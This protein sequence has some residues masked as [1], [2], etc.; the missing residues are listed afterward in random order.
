MAL[1]VPVRL[2]DIF[3][4]TVR[5]SLLADTWYR[6]PWI[7]QILLPLQCWVGDRCLSL[8][9]ARRR[10]W[11]KLLSGRGTQKKNKQKQI[12]QRKT[13]LALILI[14][15]LSDI[16]LYKSKES[17]CLCVS[18]FVCLKYLCRSGS[19][20]PESFNMAAAW[21]KDVQHCI[22]LDYNDT[23]NKL[24]KKRFM[25]SASIANHSHHSH[26]RTRANHCRAQAHNIP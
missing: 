21:F 10:L 19:D 15:T 24:F 20:W 16:P 14:L 22:F 6:V 2:I 11:R 7:Q 8:G 13:S 18:V 1:P 25:N 5:D 23:I 26:M 17:V 12:R 3:D 9:G 4:A